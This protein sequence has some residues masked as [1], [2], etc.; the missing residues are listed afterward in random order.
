MALL[1]YQLRKTLICCLRQFG[2]M[3][4]GSVARLV[5]WHEAIIA[6]IQFVSAALCCLCPQVCTRLPLLQSDHQHGPAELY[7]LLIS[8]G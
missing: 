7:A 1:E 5:Q 3:S 8:A 6:Q 4:V 2:A